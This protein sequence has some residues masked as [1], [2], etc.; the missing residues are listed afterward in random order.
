MFIRRQRN[1]PGKFEHAPFLFRRGLCFEIVD[2]RV[3]LPIIAEVLEQVVGHGL[4]HRRLFRLESL[5]H[6][7]LA[8]RFDHEVN[9]Q[10]LSFPLLCHGCGEPGVG[11][12]RRGH[13]GI[14]K[15]F[16]SQRIAQAGIIPNQIVFEGQFIQLAKLLP[17]DEFVQVHL[18]GPLGPTQRSKVAFEADGDIGEGEAAELETR[19]SPVEFVAE[20]ARDAAALCL[21]IAQEPHAVGPHKI[22]HGIN[23]LRFKRFPLLARE[24]QMS[25]PNIRR[26]IEIARVADNTG[27]ETRGSCVCWPG[28]RRLRHAHCLK[29]HRPDNERR[30][31]P[32]VA[33]E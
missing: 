8:D 1:E 19:V 3:S 29:A 20:H 16:I 27:I 4:E 24:V 13:A 26:V 23:A 22:R 2:R 30:D 12:A 9:A 21:G 15:E 17:F 10:R 18:E 7:C 32:A 25:Q 33:G 28:P 14:A 5:C 31:Q 6:E 11:C